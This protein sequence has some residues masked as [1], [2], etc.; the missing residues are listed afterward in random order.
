MFTGF[1]F[2]LGLVTAGSVAWYVWWKGRRALLRM[3][4][5]MQRLHDE[6]TIVV[7]FMHEL[8]ES[9]AEG[10]D[11]EELFKRV[12]HA[13]LVSTGGLSACVFERQGTRLR[14]VASEGLFPPHRPL[15]EATRRDASSRARFLEQILKSE[16][17][18]V[19]EGLVGIVAKTGEGI[20]IQDATNDPRVVRHE[21]PAL[22]VKSVIVVPISSRERNIAVLAI[23]N[24]TDGMPFGETDFSLA[25]SLGEQAALALQN[26]DLMA[27]QIERNRMENDLSLASNIQGMLLP[28]QFPADPMLDFAAIYLPSQKV[29][30]DFY[31]SFELG[32]GRI[33]VAVADVSGKGVPASLVMAICQSNLRHFARAHGSPAKALRML[34]EVMDEETGREMF[35]TIVYAVID[36]ARDTIT[37]ARAGH[38]LPLLCRS[39]GDQAKGGSYAAEFIH[40]QGMAV[41][42]VPDE[43]FGDSLEEVTRPFSRGD[44]LLLFTDGVTEAANVF[45]EEF[46]NARLESAILDLHSRSASEINEGVLERVATFAGTR[47]HGDDF[48]LLTIKHL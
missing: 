18:E 5:E 47:H 31:D 33:G 3:D 2:F 39:V 48:T 46:A 44:C 35:V 15:P 32:D 11:R 9:I 17:F 19:G 28:K 27:Y 41:G 30:G 14:G 40:S 43:I 16:A 21:D 10:V 20:L 34:N 36:T 38:E 8:A 22:A 25:Q 12:V 29:G 1:W 45:E 42:M 26:L 7:E 37:I 23:V 4:E 6:R 13:G 24:S